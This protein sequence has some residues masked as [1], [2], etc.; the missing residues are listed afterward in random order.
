MHANRKPVADDTPCSVCTG[1]T[2]SV[3]ATSITFTNDQAYDI[4]VDDL[5][6][7]GFPASFKVP[8]AQGG[9]SGTASHAID[10]ATAGNYSFT[11]S[12]GCSGGTVPVIKVQ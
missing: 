4:F 7:A 8:A 6:L 5:G 2:L 10:P 12:P 3:G 9:N 11:P 1:G